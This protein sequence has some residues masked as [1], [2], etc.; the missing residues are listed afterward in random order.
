MP[1]RRVFLGLAIAGAVVPY[2][3]LAVFL[4]RHGLD[5]GLLAEQV[6]ASPGSTF[7]ALDV[8]VCAA[9]VIVAVCLDP[10]ARHRA[11]VVIATLLV[12][13]SCGLPFWLAVRAQPVT[14]T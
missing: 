12:G 1:D 2:S 13:P 11:P 8:V 9:V 4:A 7:F 5:V 3:A 6:F 14:G 10:L